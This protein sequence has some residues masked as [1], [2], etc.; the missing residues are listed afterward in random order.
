M[1]P[2]LILASKKGL[3]S[4][5][6]ALAFECA[7]E[8]FSVAWDHRREMA[9]SALL[10]FHLVPAGWHKESHHAWYSGNLGWYRV[11]LARLK[12][13]F[14]GLGRSVWWHPPRPTLINGF[15]IYRQPVPDLCE[16]CLGL[17]QGSCH[18]LWVQYWAED[19]HF[20]PQHQLNFVAIPYWSCR[21]DPGYNTQNYGAIA[22]SICHGKA[23]LSVSS[24]SISTIPEPKGRASC[25]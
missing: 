14:L 23:V 20:W 11:A 13:T 6:G 24:R 19:C 8:E 4:L 9:R 3:A 1:K 16:G 21:L 15:S 18:L 17:A 25:L 5:Q 7:H 22:V 12:G 2:C 10:P